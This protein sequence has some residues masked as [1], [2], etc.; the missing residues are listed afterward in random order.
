MCIK[1]VIEASLHY[2]T[3][4]KKTTNQPVPVIYGRWKF[5]IM[6]AKA[7]QYHIFRTI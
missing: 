2:D 4:S 6:C 3:R 1:L 5:N 7:Q